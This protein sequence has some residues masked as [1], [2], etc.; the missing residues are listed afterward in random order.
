MARAERLQDERF[1]RMA[2]SLA[3]RGTGRVSPNPRVGCVLVREGTVVGWGFHEQYGGPHAEVRALAMAGA[4]ARGSTAYVTLEPC[5]HVG[6]TPPCADALVAAGVL[7]VVAGVR[8]PNPTV[9]GRGFRR[10]Q[11]AGIVCTEGILEPQCRELN[12]GFFRAMRYG[13]PWITI[14]G[15]C[16]W[17]GQLA[18][19]DG[20]SRWITGERSRRVAHVLRREHDAVLVGIGTVLTDDPALT[21]R[22]AAG[23]SPRPVVLDATLRTPPEAAL[24]SGGRA[25]LF[26]S[27]R[28]D[29]LQRR[30]LQDRGTEV[31]PV[32]EDPAGTLH[33][34]TVLSLLLRKGIL[35][36]L[37][38]GGSAI[39]GSFLR[40][41]VVDA[42]ALFLAPKFL[43]EGKP[44]VGNLHL[45]TMDEAVIL[46]SPRL[47]PLGGDVLLEGY[48]ACSPAL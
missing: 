14:K 6:K 2:L 32:P 27:E 1:L 16:S 5:A 37:V 23:C 11:D 26:C 29:P 25:L 40:E 42:V 4:Q 24:L 12:R 30:I 3:F 41:Q 45:S 22:E 33:I 46:T 20:Q 18:L 38:E 34:P 7:R 36:V 10:L 9:H 15:A 47:T 35:S 48:P 31:V 13:R 21:T 19:A 28:A 43:G 39:I 44:F 17:D 8:D